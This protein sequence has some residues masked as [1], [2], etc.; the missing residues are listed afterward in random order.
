MQLTFNFQT[1]KT[2]CVVAVN[3]LVLINEVALRW[4]RLVLGWMTVCGQ[5]NHLGM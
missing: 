5:V 4:S 1:F 2:A 3:V